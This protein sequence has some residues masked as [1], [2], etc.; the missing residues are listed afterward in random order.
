VALLQHALALEPNHA[1]AHYNLG[2]ALGQQGKLKEAGKCFQQALRLK[3]DFAEA[4]LARAHNRLVHGN[5]RQGF[6]EYE[7]R[8]QLKGSWLRPFH[9]PFW[10]GCPLAGRTILLHAEQ[11]LGDTIQFVRY[12]AVVKRYGGTVIV[13]CQES[14]LPLLGSCPGIDRLVAA[15][16]SFVKP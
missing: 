16:S 10:D 5:F 12:A 7:W 6:P 9:Q 4:H 8:W 13:E 14:L 2:L 11:G 1:E 15:G 3:P